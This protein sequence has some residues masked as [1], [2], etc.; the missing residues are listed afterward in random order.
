M[1][2]E[3]GKESVFQM[4]WTPQDYN[5]DQTVIYV[6]SCYASS[7]KCSKLSNKLTKITMVSINNTKNIEASYNGLR[8]PGKWNVKYFTPDFTITEPSCNSLFYGTYQRGLNIH[9]I[10]LQNEIQWITIYICLYIITSRCLGY[11][12]GFLQLNDVEMNY[13]AD[14]KIQRKCFNLETYLLHV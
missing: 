9:I 10:V 6:A 2:T 12:E 3:Q 11:D 4:Q 5:S 1:P 13:Q 14:A 8:L 7:E